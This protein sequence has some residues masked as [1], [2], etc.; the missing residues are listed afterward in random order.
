MV[1]PSTTLRKVNY[2]SGLQHDVHWNKHSYQAG[3]VSS[4]FTENEQ[5]TGHVLLAN[6]FHVT[7][8]W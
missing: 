7:V 6:V 5:G 3:V 1:L 4:L 2:R 8:A